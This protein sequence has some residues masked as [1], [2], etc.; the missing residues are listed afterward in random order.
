MERVGY[1]M[2]CMFLEEEEAT[3][4]LNISL[5]DDDDN[6]NNNNMVNIIFSVIFLSFR[7]CQSPLRS[8]RVIIIL[9]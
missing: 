6:N 8:P 1:D 7:L 2:L 4:F 9:F 3:D 5:P